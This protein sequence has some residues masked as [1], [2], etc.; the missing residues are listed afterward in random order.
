VPCRLF[1]VFVASVVTQPDIVS[2]L[3]EIVHQAA[4]FFAYTNPDFTVHHQAV[5]EINHL[6]LNTIWAR[7][8]PFVFFALLPAESMYSQEISI[9][10]LNDVFFGVVSGE[11]A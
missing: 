2:L 9:F 7:I 8:H 6:L 5:V 4:L 3:H 1:G 11:F 10:R